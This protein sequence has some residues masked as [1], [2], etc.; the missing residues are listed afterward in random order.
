MF[1]VPDMN[2]HQQEW[3]AGDNDDTQGNLLNEIIT[4]ENL[5]QL[6]N[7]PT[8]IVGPHRSCID[9]V[10]TDQPNLV[11][12]CSVLPSLHTSCHHQ[13]NHVE[14]NISNPP[15]PSYIRRIW[16]YQRANEDSINRAINFFNWE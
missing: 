7:E 9:L 11:N 16:H 6:V 2:C 4:S 13:I 15:P 5:F 12:N 10:I 8:H 14:L 3:W 1:N